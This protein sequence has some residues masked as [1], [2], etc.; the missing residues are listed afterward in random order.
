MG[1]LNMNSDLRKARE[2]FLRAVEMREPE[3]IPCYVFW[4]PATWY[5][6]RERLIEIMKRYP[7]IFTK[8]QMQNLNFDNYQYWHKNTTAIDDWGCVWEYT[9]E[10]L[11]GQVKV[12]PLEDLTTLNNYKPPDPLKAYGPVIDSRPPKESWSEIA[13][14]IKEER[15]RGQLT[16]GFLPH[17]CMFQRL[18][19]LRGFKNFMIDL[20]VERPHLK[21]LINM[22]LDYNIKLVN[23]WLEMDVDVIYFGDDIGAQDRIPVNP[24]IFRKYLIPAYR[25]MFRTCRRSGVHV[26]LHSDGHIIEVVEDLI[27]AGVSILNLQD[28]VNGIENISRI[29]KGKICID[30]DIDRQVILPF[31]TPEKIEEYIQTLIMKLGSKKGGLMFKAD[32]YPDVP[33]ENIEGL[34]RAFAKLQPLPG[35]RF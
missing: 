6:Y 34:C 21:E 16:W 33:I 24:K 5:K 2:N 9:F 28:R 17:G 35:T 32:C 22:V 7:S 4:P 26:Y 29:C 10:G 3:W 14:R 30:L 19:Y 1:N 25:E 8:S 18:Y 15:E 12:H 20:A 27:S 11:E 23:K 31:G 13:K